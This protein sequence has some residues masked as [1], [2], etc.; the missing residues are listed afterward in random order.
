[1]DENLW[2]LVSGSFE[3]FAS[4]SAITY[5][6]SENPEDCL[7]LTFLQLFLDSEIIYKELEASKKQS[8][9]GLRFPDDSASIVAA[10]AAV[11]AA[12]RSVLQSFL[13][14]NCH[15]WGFS[16]SGS[17]KFLHRNFFRS[18]RY[19]VLDTVLL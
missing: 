9:V 10:Y 11:I 15:V 13:S 19:P 3:K 1:M 17:A 6:D 14:S 18:L 8:P 2:G 7:S 12:I 16:P 5:Y 4:D